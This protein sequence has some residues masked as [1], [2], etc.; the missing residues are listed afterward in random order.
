MDETYLMLFNNE[1][2]SATSATCNECTSDTCNITDKIKDYCMQNDNLVTE[3]ICHNLYTTNVYK[4]YGNTTLSNNLKD[5]CK[6]YPMHKRCSCA[7]RQRTYNYDKNNLIAGYGLNCFFPECSKNNLNKD[8]TNKNSSLIPYDIY[9][10]DNSCPNNVCQI[11]I[12]DSKFDLYSSD[13]AIANNCNTTEETKFK[14]PVW[15]I[16]LIVVGVLL[17][18]LLLILLL[19]AGGKNEEIVLPRRPPPRMPAYIPTPVPTYMPMPTP[20]Q[21]PMQA[22]VALGQTYM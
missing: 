6:E 12:E 17:L 14:L 5:I 21:A 16:I 4:D 3:D 11:I 2:T 7:N 19:L 18:L 8:P 15:G 13:I 20:M 22:P 1:C 9:E 10:L